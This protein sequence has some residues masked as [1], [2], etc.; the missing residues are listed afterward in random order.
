MN[1]QELARALRTAV[2]VNHS[3]EFLA[4][5]RGRVAVEQMPRWPVRW[6][7]VLAGATLSALAIVAAIVAWPA[8]EQSV[9]VQAPVVVSEGKTDPAP[10]TS[11]PAIR[12]PRSAIRH[13]PSAVVRRN[14]N[15]SLPSAAAPFPEV[16]ISPEDARA[17][18]LLVTSARARRIPEL[19]TDS[20]SSTREVALPRIEVP[21]VI[22]EPLPEIARLEGDRP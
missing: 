19:P 5:V 16:L 14:A 6:P 18:D 8:G 15:I 9:S 22:I 3:P 2:N 11:P 12:D 10:P 21:Q 1:D 4:R 13:P 20:V 17:F 7:F